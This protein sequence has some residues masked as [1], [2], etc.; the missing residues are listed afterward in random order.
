MKLYAFITLLKV[1]TGNDVKIQC[2][3]ETTWSYSFT[4]HWEIVI[5][6]LIF[7]Y[8]IAKNGFCCCCFVKF[9]TCCA[10]GVH[11]GIYCLVWNKQSRWGTV[12][13]EYFADIW[14]LQ[15]NQ[16]LN[17]MCRI[18]WASYNFENQVLVGDKLHVKTW[19]LGLEMVGDQFA[20]VH[21]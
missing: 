17:A 16:C 18:N 11:S 21:G 12:P 10:F 1:T 4:K 3:F 13:N 5:F 8:I 6:N 7:R 19:R 2:I 14:N 20:D 15:L 9:G